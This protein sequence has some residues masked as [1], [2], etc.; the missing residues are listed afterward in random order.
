MTKTINHFAFLAVVTVE[1][2]ISRHDAQ[3]GAASYMDSLSDMAF[4]DSQATDLT[5][6]ISSK[7]ADPSVLALF[8]N[9]PLGANNVA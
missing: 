5:V 1:G 7:E 9:H 2:D 3:I 6:V 8:P 4:H